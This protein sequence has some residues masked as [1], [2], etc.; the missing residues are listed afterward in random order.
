MDPG[1]AGLVVMAQ[2]RAGSAQTL[3]APR[4]PP[5]IGRKGIIPCLDVVADGGVSSRGSISL[6]LGAIA[7]DRCLACRLRRRR[8]DEL[9]LSS[10]IAASQSGPHHPLWSL[11]DQTAEAWTI[12]FTVGGGIAAVEGIQPPCC[13]LAPTKVSLKFQRRCA[14]SR[15]VAQGAAV[16][17]QMH[18]C[19]AIDGRPPREGTGGMCVCKGPD[20]TPAIDAVAWAARCGARCR[21]TAAHLHG[22]RWHPGRYLRPGAH[23]RGGQRRLGAG[24]RTSG[25]R[26]LHRHIAAPW[27]RAGPRLPAR[28]PASTTAWLSIEA[29]K[30]RPDRQGA[31]DPFRCEEGPQ[32]HWNEPFTVDSQVVHLIHFLLTPPCR[33]CPHSSRQTLGFFWWLQL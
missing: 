28:L 5:P 27:S 16:G 12:P 20:R 25:R 11:C 32:K 23:Q 6:G 21:R 3:T 22:W 33:L 24:D 18:R 8:A 26:R 1:V 13:A 14:I 7:V 15:S 19:W 9:V 4:F 17:C 30:T 10:T 29:I 2:A 31:G